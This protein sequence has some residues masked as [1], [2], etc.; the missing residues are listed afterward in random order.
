VRIAGFAGGSGAGKTALALE[1]ARLLGEDRVLLL[2][3]DDY[4]FDLSSMPPAER[5]TRNFDE[6]AALDLALLSAHLRALRRGEAIEVPRYDMCTHTRTGS[7]TGPPRP[8]VL[9]DGTLIAADAGLR[10]ALDLLVFVDLPEDDRFARRLARDMAER[11][12]PPEEVRR[13]WEATVRPMH[14]RFVEPARALAGLV[15]RGDAPDEANAR[16]IVHLLRPGLAGRIAAAWRE[17]RRRRRLRASAR[18]ALR[19]LFARPDRLR[20]T[21]LRPEHASRA[22]LL[23]FETE[24]E[25]VT[26]IAFGILRHPRPHAFSR[27]F[28]EVLELYRADLAG[29]GPV[30]RVKG[31]NLSRAR[32][33]DGEPGGRGPGI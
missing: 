6:P 9:V 5:A 2:S 12:R 15:L 14:R 1:T 21:S 33:R 11:A 17:R 8:F 30:E 18:T 25:R 3:Q 23:D 31:V 29:D 28:H 32:G 19:G 16:R 27:Q 4:Y 26:A 10:A 24:G 13:Q 7:R 20:G 22:T